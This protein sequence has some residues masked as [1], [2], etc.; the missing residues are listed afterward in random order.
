MESNDYDLSLSTLL[1]VLRKITINFVVS[2]A[3]CA[4]VRRLI[5]NYFLGAYVSTICAASRVRKVDNLSQRGQFYVC[6]LC[7]SC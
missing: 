5:G 1:E 6:I 4:S 2:C 7:H 3:L